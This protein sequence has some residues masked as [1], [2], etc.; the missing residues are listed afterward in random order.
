MLVGAAL[1]LLPGRFPHRCRHTT[2]QSCRPYGNPIFPPR[3]NPSASL[4]H[5]GV[6]DGP[7]RHLTPSPAP[8]RLAKR[9]DHR[10]PG[11]PP[12]LLLT[13]YTYEGGQ[14]RACG[15]LR[16]TYG[17]RGRGSPRLV[18]LDVA[19][20]QGRREEDTDKDA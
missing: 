6:D 4:L 7:A 1:R 3:A 15:C 20:D 10:R 12:R 14:P 9:C 17:G 8:L 19:E 18:L 11:A 16:P 5:A 2:L 13:G